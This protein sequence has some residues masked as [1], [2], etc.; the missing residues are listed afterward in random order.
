MKTIHLA[1]IACGFHASDFSVM[2]KT[3]SLAKQNGVNVG[4]HPS[5]PDRQGFGRREMAMKPDE[6]ESCFVYQVGALQGFLVKHGLKLHHIKPHGA[7][8]GQTSRDITL[9]RAAVGV[10]KIFT[11]QD[12]NVAFVGL[13][14]TAHQKA[15]AE[16]GVK[17]IPGEQFP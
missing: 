11:S 1:N 3:V 17:F 13:P 14:G 2:D 9:A 4:A 6:L 5:L 10:C 7:I 12:Q 15:A 8:Y 16:L